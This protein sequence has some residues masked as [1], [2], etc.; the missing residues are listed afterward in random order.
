MITKRHRVH[1][2][3]LAL[4]GP[5]PAERENHRVNILEGRFGMPARDW[6]VRRDHGRFIE[7]EPEPPLR[8]PWRPTPEPPTPPPRPM[9][10]F[11]IKPSKPFGEMTDDEINDFAKQ[12][13]Q[14]M[15][16]QRAKAE[17]EDT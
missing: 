2:G 4:F 3:Q 13:V 6:L 8:N 17:A 10:R 1:R 5:H 16:E 11:F 12:F 7:P 14:G 9:R 15:A